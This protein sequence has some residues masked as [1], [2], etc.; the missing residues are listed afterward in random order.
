MSRFIPTMHL[1]GKEAIRV[2]ARGGEHV[3]TLCE[4]LCAAQVVVAVEHY[5]AWAA[6][7][8]CT[9]G[10]CRYCVRELVGPVSENPESP[11]SLTEKEQVR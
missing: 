3:E 1:H 8:Y 2:E 6:A 7:G 5:R 11:G 4:R 9:T 10:F